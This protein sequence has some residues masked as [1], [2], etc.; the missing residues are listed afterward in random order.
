[1]NEQEENGKIIWN[2]INDVSGLTNEVKSGSGEMLVNGEKVVSATKL[3]DELT[4][5][6][7]EN[8]NDIASQTQLI[9][10]AAQESLGIAVKNKQSID[11]LVVEVG[12]FKTK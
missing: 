9:N 7:R 3:L 12:K 11:G 4:R 2:I 6:L 10:E 8:I 5:I 1:M